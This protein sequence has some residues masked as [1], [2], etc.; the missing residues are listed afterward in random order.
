M[1]T[2]HTS[3]LAQPRVHPALT[4]SCWELKF[5]LLP[6][7]GKPCLQLLGKRSCILLGAPGSG[8][9][10]RTRDSS[11]ADLR[12][13]PAE[14]NSPS[15][16]APRSRPEPP[17]APRAPQPV[18]VLARSIPERLRPQTGRA[19]GKEQSPDKA[20][21][22]N[23]I[24]PISGEG[25]AAA[26]P[27]PSPPRVPVPGNA[28]G[29]AAR[30][31]TP[32][33]P[34]CPPQRG[35]S[36]G[37][38]AGPGGSCAWSGRCRPRARRCRPGGA[39]MCRDVPGVPGA[40]TA[41]PRRCPGAGGRPGPAALTCA[42]RSARPA[43]SLGC[44][45][46]RTMRPEE[47]PAS[48]GAPGGRGAGPARGREGG[49]GSQAGGRSGGVPAVHGGPAPGWRLAGLGQ[50]RGCAGPDPG[51]VPPGASRRLPRAAAAPIT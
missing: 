18:P 39:G 32:A 1:N 37:K 21:E 34:G 24:Q 44:R 31:G 38:A 6:L 29:C 14:A 40:G 11:L 45:H 20:N 41:R 42:G 33:L 12:Q 8:Q 19:K 43:P 49:G 3:H 23:T 5:S 25:S 16:A 22:R 48:H 17:A 9:L 30:G 26:P 2:T 4:E 50:G 28:P 46:R 10:P 27:A 35:A 13:Q 47:P 36:A 7:P 51:P 15:T